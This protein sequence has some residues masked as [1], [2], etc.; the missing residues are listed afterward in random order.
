MTNLTI[1][2]L[3]RVIQNVPDE[4]TIEFSNKTTTVPIT[5][6]V[7]IDISAKRLILK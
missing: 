4:F 3:K 1:E 2:I 7:E 5:K 6:K